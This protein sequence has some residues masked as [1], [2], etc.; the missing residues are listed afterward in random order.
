M[1]VHIYIE[2]F[3]YIFI[4]IYMP[5]FSM[6]AA[7]HMGIKHCSEV[8][9]SQEDGLEFS[10]GLVHKIGFYACH[11]E[12]IVPSLPYNIVIE[13]WEKQEFSSSRGTQLRKAAARR[14]RENQDR[15]KIVSLTDF[16]TYKYSFA[17][18][19]GCLLPPLRHA[20]THNLEDMYCFYR[21]PRFLSG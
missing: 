18:P 13:S 20:W 14:S 2:V 6:C 4:Y 10:A 15:S 7:P 8:I 12:K 9:V 19:A 21:A 16:S 5:V 1:Y 17:A 11:G 3:I